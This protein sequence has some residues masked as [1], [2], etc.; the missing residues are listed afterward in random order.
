MEQLQAASESQIKALQGER[1]LL[2]EKL[3]SAAEDSTPAMRENETLRTRVEALQR[4]R[5]NLSQTLHR[6]GETVEKTV[7]AVRGQFGV[8]LC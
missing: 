1:E 4:E 3:Q 6:L 7:A 8:F 2:L 5:D